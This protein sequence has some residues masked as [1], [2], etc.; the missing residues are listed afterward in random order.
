MLNWFYNLEQRERSVVMLGLT[1]LMLIL[2]YIVLLEPLYKKERQAHLNY[3]SSIKLLEFIK[4]KSA[5]VTELRQK[6][7]AQ[8]KRPADKQL[9]FLVERSLQQSKIDNSL[10]SITPL[11]AGA[12][13]LRFDTVDFDKFIKW[14]VNFHNVYTINVD[15]L[16]IAKTADEGLVRVSVLI[17]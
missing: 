4:T 7:S 15:K 5:Q 2:L 9:V 16:S 17:N 6:L 3:D 8:K 14:L 11:K 10:K 1:V 12:L 13:Q